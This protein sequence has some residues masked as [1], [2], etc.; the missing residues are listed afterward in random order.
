MS[1]KLNNNKHHILNGGDVEKLAYVE[2]SEDQSVGLARCDSQ[3]FW[4]VVKLYLRPAS[5]THDFF[6]YHV[7]HNGCIQGLDICLA[8]L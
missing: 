8:H 7:R 5:L 3:S 1:I 4:K 2:T 6:C